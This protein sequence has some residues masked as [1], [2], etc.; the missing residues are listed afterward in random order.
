MGWKNTFGTGNAG[1]AIT[2]GL[3]GTWTTTPTQWS[4]NFFENLFGYEWELTKSPAGANQWKPKDGAGEG[5]VPDAHDTSKSHTPIM[6]TTD[7]SLREDPAYEKISRRFYENPDEF[8]DAF[9]R[10]WYKLT[11]RD[12]GPVSRY[13]GPEVPEEELIWQDPIPAVTHELVNE[14]D[15]T[16]EGWPVAQPRFRSLP[17]ARTITPC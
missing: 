13:L 7:L 14:Q 5:T 10:A 17:R 12:M 4:N 2:S 11:H 15:I 1:D 16:K 3:E 9:A 8:A 6:L